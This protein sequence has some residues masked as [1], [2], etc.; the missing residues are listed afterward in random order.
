MQDRYINKPAY[1]TKD[2]QAAMRTAAKLID[3]GVDY[4]FMVYSGFYRIETTEDQGKQ[5]FVAAA[6]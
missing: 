3:A 1:E 2:K 6:A 5:L 4:T